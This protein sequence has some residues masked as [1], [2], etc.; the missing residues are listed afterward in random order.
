MHYLPKKE[1]GHG[2][3][4][5][6][7]FYN[8]IKTP[9]GKIWLIDNESAFFLRSKDETQ[10]IFNILLKIHDKL[11]KTMCIFQFS[12]V[13][14]LRKLSK[15]QSAFEH[16]WDYASLYEPLLKIVKKDELFILVGKLFNSR[17]DDIILWI[18]HC[19]SSAVDT[20]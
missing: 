8:S 19:K 16:I 17:L 5:E 3:S 7:I 15:Q 6:G 10:Y 1:G 13:A 12:I 20:I 2:R 18:D 11:L 9:N 14:K 4:I